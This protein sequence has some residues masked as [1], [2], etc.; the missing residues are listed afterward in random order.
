MGTHLFGS[1]CTTKTIPAPTLE[2]RDSDP[3]KPIFGTPGSRNPHLGTTDLK[4]QQPSSVYWQ[5]SWKQP[6]VG[7][8]LN[9]LQIYLLRLICFWN[10]VI[11]KS[12]NTRD[13]CAT[14]TRSLVF[15]KWLNDLLLQQ[16]WQV[17]TTTKFF[18]NYNSNLAIKHYKEQ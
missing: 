8:A 15:Q 4:L 18:W 13:H 17:K 14:V 16:L 9:T 2:N 5:S 3:W 1:P 12:L 11:D 6:N 10:I 7:S